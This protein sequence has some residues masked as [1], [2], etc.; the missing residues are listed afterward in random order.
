MPTSDKEWIK[1]SDELWNCPHAIGALDGKH[2]VMFAPARASSA[3][4]NYKHTHSIVLP[5]ICDVKYHF[6]LVDIGDSGRQSDD[7]VYNNS[8]NG[9]DIETNF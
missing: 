2:V 9:Y 5:G 6:I 7:S 3:Y 1:I 4:F 8:N